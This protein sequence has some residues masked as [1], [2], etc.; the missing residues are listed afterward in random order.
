MQI[1]QSRTLN[2]PNPPSVD[3]KIPRRIQWRKSALLGRFL[4]SVHK[5]KPTIR[6]K[7]G[8]IKAEQ[9][10]IFSNRTFLIV[11]ASDF[12]QN[13]GIWIHNMALLYFVMEQTNENPVAV[14]PLQ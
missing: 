13:L 11:M 8:G 14:S 5:N 10:S 6:F 9:K 3:I 7:N 2:M 4:T 12:L 1:A